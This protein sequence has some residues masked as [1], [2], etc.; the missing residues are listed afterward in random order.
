[1]LGD[2]AKGGAKRVYLIGADELAAGAVLVK[3]LASG[4]QRREPL[5]GEAR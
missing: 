5:G 4:E 2:A 1:V 3:E